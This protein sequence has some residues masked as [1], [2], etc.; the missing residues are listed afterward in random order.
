[1]LDPEHAEAKSLMLSLVPHARVVRVL[2]QISQNT[3]ECWKL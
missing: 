1:M 2:N 3:T